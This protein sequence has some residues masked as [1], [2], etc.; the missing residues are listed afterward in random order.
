MTKPDQDDPD[1]CNVDRMDTYLLLTEA[2]T[3][4]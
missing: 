2:M 3:W 4:P 1:V